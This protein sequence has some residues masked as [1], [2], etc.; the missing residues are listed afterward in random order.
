MA[1]PSSKQQQK[2]TKTGAKRAR[3][4]SSAQQAII[5]RPVRPLVIDPVSWTVLD[6][7]PVVARKA[8]EFLQFKVPRVQRKTVAKKLLLSRPKAHALGEQQAQDQEVETYRDV[9]QR[10]LA[11]VREVRL[12]HPEIQSEDE[13]IRR[14]AESLAGTA[15]TAPQEPTVAEGW[16]QL[17]ERGLKHKTSLLKSKEFKSTAEASELLG[18]GEPAVR[19][20]VREKRLFALRMPGDGEHRIPA[21]ALDPKLGGAT[22][23]AL[24]KRAG[25]AD[26]WHLYHFMTTPQGS[27]NGLRPFECLMSEENLPHAQL[28]ARAELIAYLGTSAFASLLDTVLQVL[29]AD[30]EETAAPEYEL[31]HAR[32]RP[33]GYARRGVQSSDDLP[34]RLPPGQGPADSK[35]KR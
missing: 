31:P 3:A 15:S 30:L 28:R 19:K 32:P 9:L 14:V 5:L 10:T 11:S 26:E 33:Y 4:A 35:H 18:I 6:A 1:T 17:L 27:L 25:D 21:W 2:T 8:S 29:K 22:T 7:M 12:Q 13:I 16:Q 23:E 20:R 34:P 24:L